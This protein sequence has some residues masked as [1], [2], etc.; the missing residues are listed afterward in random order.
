[1]LDRTHNPRSIRKYRLSLENLETRTMLSSNPVV[2]VFP[3]TSGFVNP[4]TINA[5]QDRVITQ[6][7]VI[8]AFQDI[9]S[10]ETLGSVSFDLNIGNSVNL[11]V[12]TGSQTFTNLSIAAGHEAWFRFEIVGVGRP[13]HDVSLTSFAY[14]PIIELYDAQGHRLDWAWEYGTE[15]ISLN[16]LIPDVYYVRVYEWNAAAVPNYTLTINAPAAVASTV[17]STIVGQTLYIEGTNGADWIEIHETSTQIVVYSFDAG[18]TSPKSQSFAKN[19]ILTIDFAGYGGN[20]TFINAY[21]GVVCTIDCRLNG[22]SGNNTLTG[23]NGNDWIYS[24][25]GNSVLTSGGGDNIIIGGFGNNTFYN[26]GSGSNCFV[27]MGENNQWHTGNRIDNNDALLIFS[28]YDENGESTDYWES[29][30]YRKWTVA[31]VLRT[32]DNVQAIYDVVGTHVL[33]H[34]SLS[35]GDHVGAFYLTICD[36]NAEIAFGGWIYSATM[37]FNGPY[38]AADMALLVH[39]V[40]H[41]WDGGRAPSWDAFRAISWNANGTLRPD[42]VSQDFVGSYAQTDVREDWA[43]TVSYVICGQVP[44]NASAK[45]LQKVALINA[46]LDWLRLPREAKSI[47]VTTHLDVIDDTDGLIS[48]REALIYAQPGDTIT[49]AASMA[50]KTI[51]LNGQ[52]LT[53]TKNITINA[54]GR[55]ITID[56]G[57]KS[58]AMIV[59]SASNT[60]VVVSLAGL[61]IT[62][63]LFASHYGGGI[64]NHATLTLT[65][66]T[67]TGNSA[68]YGGGIYNATGATLNATNCTFSNN[69]AEGAY[70]DG[71]MNYG[72]ATLI[73]CKI[74]GNNGHGIWSNARLTL[75]NCT[76]TDNANTGIYNSTGGNLTLANCTISGNS[77]NV[78]SGGIANYGTLTINNTIVAGNLSAYAQK[79]IYNGGTLT[80]RNNLI[81]NTTG[82]TT[83]VNNNNGNIV[84]TAANP[85]IPGF[86]NAAQGNFR[87]AVGSPA[88]DKGS[89]SLIPTGITIDLDGNARIANGT[90]DIGAYEYNATPARLPGDANGDGIVDLADL[91]I[92]ARNW[93]KSGTWATGDFNGDGFVDLADLTIL[94]RNWKKT[95]NGETGVETD[96]L[97]WAEALA[98][99]TFGDVGGGPSAPASTTVAV[100]Q[101]PQTSHPGPQSLNWQAPRLT[102]P[103]APYRATIDRF[104]SL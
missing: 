84:G 3:K 79:D 7:H 2:P 47:V 6:D 74:D 51:T 98:S 83:L 35:T 67:F 32:V 29:V 38:C 45:L 55:N 103:F 95:L 99:V 96:N 87:L 20:D 25:S 82:Q 22:I 11:G 58:R 26:T 75:T 60:S 23:G 88:I 73:A 78:S 17:T 59:G 34:S 65:N 49:F 31:E 69:S 68:Y 81:G 100:P 85:I 48:L 24:G 10:Q 44:S 37:T 13:W 39:E 80:G 102:N 15:T 33:F 52:T 28:Q 36:Y 101:P 56:A 90:V 19:G 93:K 30:S 64:Y 63:G 66:C 9:T 4:V 86:V 41:D 71:I 8:T 21:N 1:M 104:L 70:G 77:S 50:G 16:Y 42:A 57:G 89:N 97:S 46:F 14:P 94:A 92:L 18:R 62:N 53:F 91:T 43:E 40:A 54:T 76:V 12:I 61:T 5:S 27:W 72:T